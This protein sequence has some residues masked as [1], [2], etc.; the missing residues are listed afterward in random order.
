MLFA[1]AISRPWLIGPGSSSQVALI[2]FNPR[3]RQTAQRVYYNNG[4]IGDIGCLVQVSDW[5]DRTAWFYGVIRLVRA[6]NT[7]GSGVEP[8]EQSS[9]EPAQTRLATRRTPLQ[10]VQLMTQDQDFGFQLPPGFE[11]IKQCA[12]EQETHR[13]HPVIMFRFAP[14][15]ESIGWNFRKRQPRF[16]RSAWADRKHCIFCY[17]TFGEESHCWCRKSNDGNDGQK[18]FD[19]LSLISVLKV[20]LA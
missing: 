8:D 20:I 6:W 14:T 15:R 16:S 19:H 13:D 18:V 5:L 1:V 12:E 9:V 11:P 3:N 17:S 4:Y 10:N 2:R 7:T